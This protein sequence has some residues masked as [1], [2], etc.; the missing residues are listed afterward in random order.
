MKCYSF[1]KMPPLAYLKLGGRAD[2]RGRK[3]IRPRANLNSEPFTLRRASTRDLP[4]LLMVPLFSHWS[5]GRA[6]SDIN[7][8]THVISRSIDTLASFV[9]KCDY[10]P[11]STDQPACMQQWDRLVAP[12]KMEIGVFREREQSRAWITL[13]AASWSDS[14]Y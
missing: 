6:T 12:E 2:S 14:T 9:I 10:F 3:R 7:Y 11:G 4:I 13:T 8:I 5:N 1:H